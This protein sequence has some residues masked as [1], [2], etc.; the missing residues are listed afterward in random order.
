VQC[1]ALRD[2]LC[3]TATQ[4]P[5]QVPNIIAGNVAT[6]IANCAVPLP[7]P[8]SGEIKAVIGVSCLVFVILTVLIWWLVRAKKEGTYC[9]C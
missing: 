4:N 7:V 6:Y 1:H 9:C 3:V 5:A 2:A 8:M